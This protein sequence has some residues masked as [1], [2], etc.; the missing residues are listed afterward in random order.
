M[1]MCQLAMHGAAPQ[2][3]SCLSDAGVCLNGTDL[4]FTEFASLLK[5]E[6][7]AIQALN[8]VHF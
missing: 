8:C 6:S 7:S 2:R 4:C 5:R 3:A 1:V